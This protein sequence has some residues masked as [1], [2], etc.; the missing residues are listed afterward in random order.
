MIDDRFDR[1]YGSDEAM[2]YR[3]DSFERARAKLA[4][5][6]GGPA[7]PAGRFVG[8]VIV[9]VVFLGLPALG[10]F[11]LGAMLASEG[12]PEGGV[13][14]GVIGLLFLWGGVSVFLGAKADSPKRALKLYYRSL[15]KGKHARAK[16]ILLPGDLDGFPRYQPRVPG[17]GRPTGNPLYFANGD[18]YETYWNELLRSHALPYCL[19]RLKRIRIRDVAPDVK[20][21]EFDLHLAM[22]TSLWLLLVP[23]SLL[24]AA[25]VDFATRK[26]VKEPLTKVLVK[27]EDE[28]HLLN[29]SWWEF[30]EDQ[31]EWLTSDSAAPPQRTVNTEEVASPPSVTSLTS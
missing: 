7:R 23:V 12:K 21:A 4:A 30:D 1:D 19:V 11:V 20:I 25:V 27:V 24:V 10:L 8:P 16:K 3:R 28:W 14:V 18:D 5:S 9:A 29:G 22:N 17:L 2:L 6:R 15:A 26:N 31:T 13:L